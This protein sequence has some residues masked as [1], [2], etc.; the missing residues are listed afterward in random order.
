[1]NAMLLSGARV[2]EPDTGFD[3][4]RAIGIAEGVFV[5]PGSLPP[6]TPRL[7]LSG[8]VVCP[9]FVDL[10]VHLREPGQTHKEDIV[11]GTRAAAAGG[12]TTVLAM[13]NTVPPVDTPE[14]LAALREAIASRAC[15][16][17]LQT[18]ALT[19]GRKGE[20]LTDAAALKRAG[21][22][23]LTDDGGCIQSAALMRA[24]LCAAGAAG[25][26]VIE[27]AEDYGL[28]AG[29]ALHAGAVAA[30]LG[31]RGSPAVAEDL[32]VARDLL[33]ARDTGVAVHV[34]H[35]SSATAVALL[36][37]ARTEGIPVSA[38]V[39]PHHLLLTDEAGLEHGTLAKMN[40]PL[41]GEADRQALLAALRDG[42]LC[43][44]ATD[45][46][47][48]SIAEKQLPLPEAPF[49]IIGLET[50]V[51]LCLTE[52]YHGGLLSLPDLVARFTCG[53]CA[54]L[55]LPYGT[56]APGRSADLTILDLEHERV[57]APERFES[58]ARNTPFTGRCCRGA[59]AA[60]LVAG[61]WAYSALSGIEAT[62]TAPPWRRRPG[63]SPA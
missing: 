46:A 1:M 42:T 39:T 45:H 56:L 44:I 24:A 60:T 47:P 13:P 5:A 6:E 37:W 38:E 14:A 30:R 12:F 36:R 19:L 4:V 51:P 27:H 33:L 43:A 15:V 41:R 31:V 7:D 8:L 17:V 9:G 28:S 53:P 16:R 26:P 54:A 10:H 34:Q 25:L 57:V 59:V 61:R 23:A 32:I 40:P 20:C 3:G 29:G 58:R 49:G 21:A 18:A 11:T 35:V 22:A 63:D 62:V 55:G 50:A 52:L 2:I 48:H